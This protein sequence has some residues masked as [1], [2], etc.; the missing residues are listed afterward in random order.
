[1]RWFGRAVS[2][3]EG[4]A[5]A[6]S[7]TRFW[8]YGLMPIVRAGGNPD[9]LRSAFGRV[10]SQGPFWVPSSLLPSEIVTWQHIDASTARATVRYGAL[11]QAIDISVADDG[12]PTQVVM[13]RW[14]NAN[15][16]QRFTE[17]PFGGYLSQFVTFSGYRL[18]TRVEGGNFP[19]TEDY[20]P[21]YKAR[22][23]SL[24]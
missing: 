2:G 13:Q 24:F 7:W 6:T 5:P 17:Q 21:F 8:L 23:L 4:A 18:P 10:V 1:M 12:Q 16:E 11:S 20:F 15:P 19:G 9:H 22:I 14:S 3:S